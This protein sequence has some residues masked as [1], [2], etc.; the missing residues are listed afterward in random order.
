MP[1]AHPTPPQVTDLRSFKQTAPDKVARLRRLRQ[2]S[3]EVKQVVRAG[4][5]KPGDAVGLAVQ[6]FNDCTVYNVY[7]A[8][9][10]VEGYEKAG[11]YAPGTAVKAFGHA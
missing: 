7:E 2:P 8:L 5:L 9:L 6:F 1:Q 4:C 10:Y 11:F 3:A